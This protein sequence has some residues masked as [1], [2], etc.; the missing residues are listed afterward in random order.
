[1]KSAAL[2]FLAVFAALAGS[3]A[4]FVLA[5]QVQLGLNVQ[6]NVLGSSSLY[7]QARPGQ[8]REGLEVYRANGCVYCHSQQVGQEGTQCEIVLTDLGTN[9]AATLRALAVQHPD[10][11]RPGAVGGLPE[12]VAR[13]SDMDAAGT[14]LKDLGVGGAKLEVRV[15][16]QGPDIARGWGVR[17]TVAQDYLYD[18][19]VQPGSRRVGPDLANVGAR[20]PDAHWQLRHLYAPQSDVP[21]STMPPYRFLFET[22][23]VGREASAD[24]LQL[25]ARL[26]PPPGY[27]IVPKAEARALVAYLLSLRADE[28]LFEAPLTLASST[29]PTASTN[30]AVPPAATK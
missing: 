14:L 18:D 21:G 25:P 19:P 12:V 11:A 20:L 16:P 7:P 22:R 1:M 15:V 8:A 24:A 6:T 17:R 3:W 29:G 9:A 30:T 5:P 10:L 27:E 4:G 26:A 28:P 13:V 2:I 23:K